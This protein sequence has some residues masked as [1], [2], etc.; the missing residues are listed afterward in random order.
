MLS[1]YSPLMYN[2]TIFFISDF[3]FFRKSGL[4]QR[5]R[6]DFRKQH[7]HRQDRG[8]AA[9]LRAHMVAR[10]PSEIILLRTGEGTF[11]KFIYYLLSS[12]WLQI[13]SGFSLFVK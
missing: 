8:S 11:Q 12:A 13:I 2:I 3:I 7:N 1:G 4:K 5:R 9:S 6:Q 10:Y